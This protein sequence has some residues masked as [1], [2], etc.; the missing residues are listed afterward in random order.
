MAQQAHEN[1]KVLIELCCEPDSALGRVAEQRPDCRTIRITRNFADVSSKEGREKVYNTVKDNPGADLWCSLPC[2]D[3][4][5]MQNM[6]IGRHGPKYLAKLDQRRA[7]LKKMV[8]TFVLAA[9]VIAGAGGHVHFEWPRNCQGWSL[10][11]DLNRCFRDLNMKKANFDGCQVGVRTIDGKHPI[12]KPW[13]VYTSSDQLAL[14]LTGRRCPDPSGHGHVACEGKETTQTGKYPEALAKL[15]WK[16]ISRQHV[17]DWAYPAMDLDGPDSTAGNPDGNT[18][19]LALTEIEKLIWENLPPDRR[20]QLV[21]D[22]LKL[23]RVSGHRPPR[24]MLR[25]LRRRGA[26]PEITAAVKHLKCDA[27][28]ENKPPPPRP[29][30]SIEQ[31][32]I[33]WETIGIDLKEAVDPRTNEKTKYLAI[34]DEGDK[35]TLMPEIF[36]IQQA[37][38]R[39]ATAEEVIAALKTHWFDHYGQPKTIRLDPEGAL[40]SV[41][42]LDFILGRGILLDTCCTQAHWQNGITERAIR[43]IFESADALVADQD[44]NMREAVHAAVEAHN[45]ME[46]VEGYAPMQWAFGRHRSWTGNLHE[47]N[48]CDPAVAT[49]PAFLRTLEIREKA[50]GIISEKI[51]K[52]QILRARHTRGQPPTNYTPGMLVCVWR[53]GHL[54]HG[55]KRSKRRGPGIDKGRWYGPGTV[56]GTQTHLDRTSTALPAR[57]VWVV[58]GNRLWRCAT[59]QL[60]TA[61]NRE[62]QAYRSSNPTPWTFDDS[63]EGLAPGEFVAVDSEYL[64]GD[65]VDSA[66]NRAEDVEMHDRVNIEAEDARDSDGKNNRNEMTS[67]D[68]LEL[69]TGQADIDLDP[70][71]GGHPIIEDEVVGDDIE[72]TEP[73]RTTRKRE[74]SLPT[75]PRRRRLRVKTP[76]G[77]RNKV[78]ADLRAEQAATALAAV[79]EIADDAN[80][81]EVAFPVL[82][83]KVTAEKFA[84][85]PEKVIT[86]QL[87]KQRAEINERRLDPKEREAVQNAKMVEIKEW[88]AEKVVAH[89]PPHL[90]P[91]VGETMRMRWVLTWKE[92]PAS[93]TGKRA[94]ARLVIMGFQDPKLGE[95][96]VNSPTM[97]KRGR[98]LLCHL[99][100]HRGWR[101]QKADVK[102]AFLQGQELDPENPKFV[103]A[104][105]ELAQA[106]GVAPG[107]ALLL[108]KAAY[109]LCQAPLAWFEAVDKTLTALGGRRCVAD[110][111]I[112][113]FTDDNGKVIGA[114]GTHV[115]DF[116]ITGDKSSAEWK[117][118]LDHL[119]RAFRW[120]PWEEGNFK[121]TGLELTQEPGGRIIMSQKH[122]LNEIEEIE[123]DHHRRK[124]IHSPVTEKE[125]TQL[126]GALGAIQ[127][128]ATQTLPAYLA[129]C[130]ILQSRIPEA[131]VDVLLSVNKVIR[132]MKNDKNVELWI[133]PTVGQECVVVAWSDAAWANRPDG[134]STGGLFVGMAP[135]SIKNGS[136]T[137]V[138]MISHGS[139]KLPRVARSSLSAEVQNLTRTE[140]EV[141]MVRMLWAELTNKATGLGDML[142]GIRAVPATIVIDAK[143]IY[144]CLVKRTGMH[145]L[146]EK[147]TALELMAYAQCILEVGIDTRW[148]HSEANLADSLTK[149]TAPGPMELYMKNHMWALVEDGAQL[150]AKK[151]K[152]KGLGRFDRNLQE[153][154]FLKSLSEVMDLTGIDNTD[155]DDHE[156][157]D[158]MDMRCGPEPPT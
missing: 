39:N 76:F 37:V 29:A 111:C 81:I 63:T 136:R 102:A 5:S 66:Q 26:P 149:T 1:Q 51:L 16:G 140:D 104:A 133:E 137:S 134:G 6:N 59:E 124:D 80:V 27:C 120:T 44:I 82:E 24:V 71:P 147:R 141:F 123:L 18:K 17:E 130:S 61:S 30:A 105:P 144:D 85:N 74:R 58:M 36:T 99:A 132:T 108:R 10:F 23:H 146:K 4:S 145:T 55:T 75:P 31:S 113:V 15:I 60:R 9:T 115:D 109:G 33:P 125:R 49:N 69:D 135:A 119:H 153:A 2:T 22:M 155:H 48:E 47:N 78:E 127:W 157:V 91:T 89:L 72:E 152:T 79:L 14:L 57:K 40:T 13:T 103:A 12:Y 118:V 21:Q 43:T 150:S 142:D 34:I 67:T 86:K 128:A 154:D 93:E 11:P 73:D 77:P 56:L 117:D 143:S 112:W 107:A 8:T 20:K 68:N 92:D 138:T 70:D 28:H 84:R 114:I 95:D 19:D 148:C 156:F 53:T 90:K 50:K 46:R 42:F 100:C 32:V 62:E 38:H 97:T 106:M 35:L 98:N 7:R 83:D 158:A 131:D 41:E 151:R 121:Q 139:G 45:T 122:Y 116:L 96:P 52:N 3:V 65:D 94:K 126:R 64:P 25:T 101:M 110:P 129:E 54:G 88:L 87:K